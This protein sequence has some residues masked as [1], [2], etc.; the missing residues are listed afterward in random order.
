MEVGGDRLN[1]LDVTVIRGNGRIEF[2]WYHKPTFSDRYLNFW[3]QHPVS[4]KIGTIAG[5]VDR[6]VL[7][8]NPKFHYNNFCF[9][10]VLLENDYPLNFIFENIRYRLRKII[11]VDN[12]KEVVE[13]NCIN[14]EE[15]SWFTVPFVRGVPEKFNRLNSEN[16]R[17]A[18]YS[19][20]KLQ[21][22][23]RV[24]RDPLL[25]EKKSLNRAINALPFE[26]HIPGY[27]FCGPGTRLTKRLARGDVSIGRT[28]FPSCH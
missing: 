6:I 10:I 9:I 4:Q 8:S 28:L 16:M 11:M 27:Q 20:N 26:S 3:S 19:S 7:L 5:L 17:V 21:E 15:C 13:E 2:N 22:F 1:F 18:Y 12:R 24:H 23:I 25:R 14:K